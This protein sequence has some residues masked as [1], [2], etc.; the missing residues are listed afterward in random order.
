[1]LFDDASTEAPFEEVFFS[2]K[3]EYEAAWDS[4]HLSIVASCFSLLVCKKTIFNLSN[5][6]QWMTLS[7]ISRTVTFVNSLWF[8]RPSHVLRPLTSS[9]LSCYDK[10]SL[11]SRILISDNLFFCSDDQTI[12]LCQWDLWSLGDWFVKFLWERIK[13]IAYTASIWSKT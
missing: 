11:V 5:E 2:S 9:N 7:L 10:S 4:C 6:H 13:E 3:W 12:R 8:G 1:M